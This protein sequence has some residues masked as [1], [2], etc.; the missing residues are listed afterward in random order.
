MFQHAK[1]YSVHMTNILLRLFDLEIKNEQIIKKKDRYV[2]NMQ[3]AL[4][5]E[6]KLKA[7]LQDRNSENNQV[8]G[9]LQASKHKINNMENQSKDLENIKIERDS[10]H[11][12]LK[13]TDANYW[14]FKAQK[15]ILTIEHNKLQRDYKME[16]TL[17]KQRKELQK[18]TMEN[19]N[20][21]RI[22]NEIQMQVDQRHAQMAKK[23]QKKTTFNEKLNKLL[24][25][26]QK[27]KP[28]NYDIVFIKNN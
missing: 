22:K 5:N 18:L 14:G 10:L 9:E 23:F 15:D 21:Y 25:E 27:K 6:Q 11:V 3:G 13:K 20:A 28:F 19:A 1:K 7:E 16:E 2:Q 26:I 17:L 4:E 24:E 8:L 12:T